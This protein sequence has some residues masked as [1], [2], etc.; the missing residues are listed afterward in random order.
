MIRARNTLATIGYAA[1]A[2]FASGYITPLLAQKASGTGGRTNLRTLPTFWMPNNGSGWIDFVPNENGQIIIP[3][4]LNGVP[5]RALVDT[6]VPQMVISKSFADAHHLPLTPWGKINSFAGSTD[7]Y[8]TSNISLSVG[9]LHTTMPGTVGVTDLGSVTQRSIGN[10]DIVIGLLI[11]GDVG[12]EI[13]Q[14]HHRFRLFRSGS[15]KIERPIPLRLAQSRLFTNVTIDNHDVT[16]VVIDTGSDEQVYVS[17]DLAKSIDFKGRTD[18]AAAGVGGIA[19]QP[20]GKLTSFRIG[21]RSV[22]VAYATVGGDRF[23]AEGGKASIGMGVLQNYNMVVD[24]PGGKMTLTPRSIPLPEFSKST[25][26][27][28]GTYQDG[29]ITIV[30][31]MKNSPAAKIDLKAGDQICSINGKPMS[32]SMVNNHWGRAAPGTRYELGLCDGSTRKMTLQSFY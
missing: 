32:E 30:H 23:K 14:D 21:E 5:V 13:D 9:A 11:L 17:E 31:V 15:I 19:V 18:L 4:T 29:R 24:P 8:I 12:W 26:G 7:N 10:F 3:V 22:P 6:G 20:F 2:C 1:L 16:Q 27:V 28:Q 25:S